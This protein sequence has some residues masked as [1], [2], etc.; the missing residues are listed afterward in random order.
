MEEQRIIFVDPLDYIFRFIVRI[1]TLYIINTS[2]VTNF[3]QVNKFYVNKALTIILFTLRTIIIYYIIMNKPIIQIS[4]NLR[5][6]NRKKIIIKY[7]II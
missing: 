7:R 4:I 2:Y 1:I 5:D 3:F 6:L